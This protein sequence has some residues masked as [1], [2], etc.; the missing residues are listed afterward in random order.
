MGWDCDHFDGLDEPGK[1]VLDEP[2][3]GH[4]VI[5]QIVSFY[6]FQHFVFQI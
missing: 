5:G 2:V 4:D 6:D 3:S 1:F